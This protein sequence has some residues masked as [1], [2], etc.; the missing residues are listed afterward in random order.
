MART[1]TEKPETVNSAT[2]FGE[3]K[4][5]DNRVRSRAYE[6]YG[7]RRHSGVYGDATADWIAAERELQA[8]NEGDQVTSLIRANST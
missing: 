3:P 7:V 8:R 6:L 4:F 5:S 2:R 1:E